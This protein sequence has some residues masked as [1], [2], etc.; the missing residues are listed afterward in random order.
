MVYMVGFKACEQDFWSVCQTEQMQNTTPPHPYSANKW[1]MKFHQKQF[2]KW[3]MIS[4]KG[5]HRYRKEGGELR[6]SNV[7]DQSPDG[8]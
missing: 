5:K 4:R 2:L 1:R 3:Q 6:V 7:S 8:V